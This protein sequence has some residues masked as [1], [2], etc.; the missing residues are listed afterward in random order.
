MRTLPALLTTA[1]LMTASAADARQSTLNMTCAQASSLVGRQGAIV[2]STGR[3][4][5]DRFV[6]NGA[7]CNPGT[8]YT[9][10][11]WAPT[12][13]GRCQIGY[14]CRSGTPYETFGD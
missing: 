11:A 10:P 6:A 9:I 12:R 3:Y 14:L 5:F 8:D 4:T 1:L 13:D 2:L 7:F